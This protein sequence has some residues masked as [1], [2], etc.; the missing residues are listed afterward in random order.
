MAEALW[1]DTRHWES[2]MAA[3]A[4]GITKALKG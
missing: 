2:T 3:I 4:N 1:L